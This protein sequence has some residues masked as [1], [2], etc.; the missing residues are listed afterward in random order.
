[1]T[2]SSTVFLGCS[3]LG[4]PPSGEY[5][6]KI[7]KSPQYN[8]RREKFVNRQQDLIE[9]MYEK[10]GFWEML[11]YF[12]FTGKDTKP[13]KK[14]PETR[15][16]LKLFLNASPKPKFIWFGH[17]TFMVNMNGKI[18]LFDPVF[19]GSAAPVSFLSKRFQPPVLSLE[20]LPKEISFI[21]ISHDHYDHLDMETV[22]FFRDKKLKFIV[23]LGVSSHLRAWGVPEEN[24]REL[25]WRQSVKIENLE[26]T[27]TPAQHFSGR[28]ST[29][30]NDTLWASWVVRDAKHSLY[31]SGDSGYDTHFKE[32]GLKYGPFDLAFIENG[33]YDQ[34]WRSIH[35]MPEDSAQAFLDLGAKEYVPV[36]WSMFDLSVHSWYDPIEA[37][38]KLAKEK[39]IRLLTPKPGQIVEAGSQTVFEKW[40][41]RA[42]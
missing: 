3:A 23:P 30:G 10:S 2:L 24:I 25:D 4:M 28:R 19:S 26:F 37:I 40:W 9:K 5:L 22:N 12:L 29:Q 17:S 32:I 39:G 21:V 35:M 31:F 38:E 11:V 14:L 42:K 7:Q 13:Q 8:L 20:E 1:M 34:R 27:C 15:P 36:H 18:L 33:Q 41:E 16:D 6:R